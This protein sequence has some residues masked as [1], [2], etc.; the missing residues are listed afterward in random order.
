M[1]K[2]ELAS[3]VIHAQ[4]SSSSNIVISVRVRG[5]LDHEYEACGVS[6]LQVANSQ[7]VAIQY[8]AS[9]DETFSL[10]RR[11]HRHSAHSVK[12]FYYDHVFSDSVGQDEVFQVSALPLIDSVL[13]G[14][15]A[16]IFAYGATG[17]G[18]TYTMVGTVES[19][20]IMVLALRELFDRLPDRRNVNIKCSFIEIYN[21][22]VRDLL[23]E[24]SSNQVSLD[25]RDDPHAG[26][27][28]VQGVTE[29][30]GI[31]RM[32]QMMELLILGNAR[33]STEPTAANE[34]SSRSHAILQVVLEQ[35]V[36]DGETVVSKLSLI[37]LAG[38]E[39]ARDTQNRG[40]RF[41]EGGNIN[42]SLLALGNC[43]KALSCGRSGEFVPYRDSKLTRLLR[44]SLGGNCQTVMIAN[45]SP[46]VGH[47]TESVNTLKFAI[48]AKNVKMKISRTSRFDDPQA[49]I[50]KY[51][52]IIAELESMVG[53]LE[54][55]LC[56][57][58]KSWDFSSDDDD[59]NED[60]WTL[61]NS[62]MESISEQLR[63]RGQLSQLDQQLQVPGENFGE[64]FARKNFL[65]ES[66]KSN[67]AKTSHLH[68]SMSSLT[69]RRSSRSCSRQRRPT[70]LSESS[71]SALL[72]CCQITQSLLTNSPPSLMRNK[73]TV[74]LQN[75]QPCGLNEQVAKLTADLRRIQH[76]RSVE[77]KPVWPPSIS[78]KSALPRLPLRTSNSPPE[79]VGQIHFN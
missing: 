38:S 42:K 73:S 75:V 60:E 47:Y 68:R 1:Q 4:Q 35:S 30:V 40:M 25:I 58:P 52:R 50:R 78:Q 14:I 48:R 54:E 37:D 72:E 21:E 27:T 61:K 51:Q 33:R 13:R 18:K 31:S 8:D 41:I 19:P 22:V 56:R 29:I 6:T 67:A 12:H 23:S 71:R 59:D 2:P 44:D 7:S 15:N 65:L 17:A 76:M 36:G 11:P 10:N 62:L 39:R 77:T 57:Q 20:G 64:L 55:Q 69:Q 70:D 49:E 79:L 24:R 5:L 45:V 32:D 53:G 46:F 74:S 43:I 34:T 26:C 3:R 63:V 9:F 66:L 16:T 28:F